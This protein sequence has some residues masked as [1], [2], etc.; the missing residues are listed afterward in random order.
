M[1]TFRTFRAPDTRS[2]LAMVKAALGP[3]AVILATRDVDNGLFRAKEIE[4]TAALPDAPA[5][6]KALPAKAYNPP[7]PLVSLPAPAPVP[8]TPARAPETSNDELQSLRASLEE[9]RRELRR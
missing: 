5:Q 3:D 4:V 8:V 1:S 9:M 2:A 7:A 6:T